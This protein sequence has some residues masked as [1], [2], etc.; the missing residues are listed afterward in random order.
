MAVQVPPGVVDIAVADEAEAVP[1]PSATCRTSRGRCRRGRRPTSACC[2]RWCR[3]TG[4]GSTTC[5]GSSTRCRHRLGARAAPPASGSAW[6]RRWPASQGGRS[7][8]WR[9]THPP[10]RRHRHRRLRQG[11]ALHAAL[12]RVRPAAAVPVRHAGDDGRSGGRENRPGAPLQPPVR[13]RR[14]SDG[15]LLHHRAAQD[16]YG[17]GGQAMA[18]GSIK[19]PMFTVAWPT[20]EFGGMGLEGSVKLGYRNELAAVEDPAERRRCSRTWWRSLRARQ[21][22]QHRVALRDRRRHRSR[23][24][25]GAGSPSVRSFPPRPPGWGPPRTRGV[26]EELCWPRPRGGGPPAG[27]GARWPPRHPCGGWGGWESWGCST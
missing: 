12:R 26:D 27:C 1:R 2:A 16:A 7:A 18:G 8:S 24:A 15:A 11:G 17:L 13:D 20:G 19:A 3:R 14:Q 10:R 22:R 25:P 23:P 4:C 6:S 9:T 21:G 5:A